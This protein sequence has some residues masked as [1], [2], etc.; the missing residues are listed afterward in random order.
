MGTEG[1]LVLLGVVWF[2][3]FIFSTTL[4]EASHA[5]A[6]NLLGDS[7]A[8]REGQITLNPW[9]HVRR[10]PLGM[11][12]IP[13]LSFAF[14]G[15]MIGWASAPYDPAWAHR[16]PKRAA[17]MA[18]AGPAANLG[19][20]LLAAVGIRLGVGLGLLEPPR[21]LDFTRMVAGAGDSGEGLAMVLSLVFSLNLLLF[22][23]NL[24]PLP[25]LDGFGG[26]QLAMSDDLARSFQNLLRQPM[27]GLMGI[28]IA[29][30]VFGDVFRPVQAAAVA[31]LYPG[32]YEG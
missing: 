6:A 29:W 24:L 7:T 1:S 31:L 13:I 15:W 10:E 8:Y 17:L 3:V 2:L 11:V 5:W 12:V 23:F 26:I 9:P 14:Y 27:I 16:Q 18:L 32:L 25:P 19:L 4:H 28:V 21:F 20:V 22:T 30:Q